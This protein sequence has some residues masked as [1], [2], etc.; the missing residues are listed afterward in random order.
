MKTIF[1]VYT[2]SD[3][4][5]AKCTT[6]KK[7]VFNTQSKVKVGDKLISPSYS[8]PMVVTDILED[9]L[10]TYYCKSTGEL[11]Y[12]LTSTEFRTIKT[13]KIMTG[14]DPD[15]VAKKAGTVNT[16]CR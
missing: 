11:S 2:N 6:L 3:N 1:V 13:L 12:V 5:D 8:T 14:D 15:V 10:F 9:D 4:V 16:K 7:Y